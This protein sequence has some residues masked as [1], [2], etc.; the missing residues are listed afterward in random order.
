MPKRRQTPR[1]LSRALRHY[2]T[3]GD[4]EGAKAIAR[5]DGTNPW[6][7]IG[8]NPQFGEARRILARERDER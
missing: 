3:T 4:F 1:P 5:E 6:E 8:R 7:L 2:L